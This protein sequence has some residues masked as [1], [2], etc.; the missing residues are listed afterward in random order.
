[1]T[2]LEG[3]VTPSERHAAIEHPHGVL[4]FVLGLLGVLGVA[5]LG[6][7]AWYLASRAERQALAEKVRYSNQGFIVAGKVL[8]IIATVMLVLAL[9]LGVLLGLV[10]LGVVGASGAG[11]VLP[12]TDLS[13]VVFVTT[14]FVLLMALAF[15]IAS[16]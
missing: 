5:V 3:L 11:G 1:M 2:S 6:P 7:V 13:A 9:V 10:L 8:G 15:A 12:T 4:V 14:V 16:D